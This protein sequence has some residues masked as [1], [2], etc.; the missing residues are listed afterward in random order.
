MYY[1]ANKQFLFFMR[2]GRYSPR[3]PKESIKYAYIRQLKGNL[4]DDTCLVTKLCTWFTC[5]NKKVARA[6]S[7]TNLCRTTCRIAAEKVV[8]SA[9]ERR[10]KS[11]GELLR[12]VRSINCMK[13]PHDGFGD[14]CHTASSE[15][16][17]YD[18]AYNA[19]SMSVLYLSIMY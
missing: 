11:A 9:L 2:K 17:F 4:R 6:M 3:E 10:R 16:W 18:T 8:F 15:P 12:C 19:L 1:T 14:G 5:V 13:F 7:A